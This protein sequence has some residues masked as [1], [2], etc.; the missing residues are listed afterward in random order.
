MTIQEKVFQNSLNTCEYISGYKNA[1]STITVHCLI[2]D[3][4]FN[5]KWENVRRDNRKHY[6]CPECQKEAKRKR[7]SINQEEVECAYCGKKFIIPKSKTQTTKSG[8]HFCCR[9]HKD[10]AQ[11][12][13][14][15][16]KFNLLRPKHYGENTSDYRTAAFR[17]YE[18]KCCVCGWQEDEQILEVHHKDENHNNNEISNL[19]IICPICHRKITSH[20]YKLTNDYKLIHL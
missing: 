19:C 17:T 9:E 10:L 7:D 16:D 20:L 8:L 13:D 3:L 14:S 2:H 15:G 4:T 18:H 6:I 1:Q 11:R 5:T 12:I